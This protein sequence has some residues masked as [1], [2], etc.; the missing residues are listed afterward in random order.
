M[1]IVGVGRVGLSL[2]VALRRAGVRV[3]AFLDTSPAAAQQATAV[4]GIEE[5]S[6]LRALLATAPTLVFLTVPD[7]VVASAAAALA[8]AWASIP[9]DA[10]PVAVAHTSGVTPVSAL[11]PCLQAGAITFA[12]H[13]LQTFAGHETG[14][15]HFAD[16]T[17]AVTAGPRGGWEQGRD[18]A[19]VLGGRPV[20]LAEEDRALYHAAACVASNYLV[21]LEHLAERMFVRAGL[22]S[23]T[24]LQSFL[25]LVRGAV[26]NLATHGTVDALTGPLSRGDVSTIQRHL[27]TLHEHMPDVEALYSALGL[28]T[29]ELVQARGTV[30]H[31]TLLALENLLR[32]EV[33]PGGV[34]PTSGQARSASSQLIESSLHS[35]DTGVTHE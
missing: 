16:A 32:T 11:E 6:D 13:P 3:H 14:S 12:F 18:L 24:A 31:T 25:P 7:S 34:D 33:N 21:T 27:T 15:T 4:L 29:L 19:L 1:A 9:A 26:D 17:I 35:P 30:D 10:Q 5:S 22:P 28:A 23:A 8:Q 2:A 20:P